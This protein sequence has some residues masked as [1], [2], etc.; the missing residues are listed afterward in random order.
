MICLNLLTTVFLKRFPIK[1]DRFVFRFFVVVFIT[2][3]SFIKKNENDPS[4]PA[5][6][7]GIGGTARYCGL[8]GTAGHYWVLGV[9]GGTV[10][11][12]D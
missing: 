6:N 10:G 7:R 2:K 4:L 11:Y 12:Y 3:R 5:G 8:W 9:L 1:N